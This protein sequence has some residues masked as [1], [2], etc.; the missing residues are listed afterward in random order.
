MADNTF[1]QMGNGDA[2]CYPKRHQVNQF[3]PTLDAADEYGAFSLHTLILTP[4][5][6]G[7]N[8]LRR[9]VFAPV[10]AGRLENKNLPFLE[11]RKKAR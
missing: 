3:L 9:H 7:T 1:V 11:P 8:P 2:T 6:V 5:I 10:R 4:V